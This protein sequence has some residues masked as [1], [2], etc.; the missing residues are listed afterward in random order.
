MAAPNLLAI[1]NV[2]GKSNFEILTPTTS[3]VLIN[4]GNSGALVKIE[5]LTLNNYVSVAANVTLAV[6]RG[7]TLYYYKNNI[8]VQP[9]SV[10]RV[11]T[12]DTCVYL[13]E[14]DFIQANASIS[15]SINISVSYELMS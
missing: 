9:N 8:P 12:R 4:Y 5:S 3:I 10:D 1:T 13:E 7:G 15:G 6:N 11:V 2:S 14:G